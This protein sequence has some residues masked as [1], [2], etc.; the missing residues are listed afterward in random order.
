LARVVVAHA[1]E[2]VLAVIA[3]VVFRAGAGVVVGLGFSKK[4]SAYSFVL[5]WRGFLT[6][7]EGTEA[8]AEHFFEITTA[9][10]S[11]TGSVDNGVLIRTF[12]TQF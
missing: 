8:H 9:N 4:I 12:A 3:G 1:R 7:F 11:L 5:T 2:E 6:R 10:T